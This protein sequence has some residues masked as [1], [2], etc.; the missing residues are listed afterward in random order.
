MKAAVIHEWNTFSLEEVDTPVIGKE[1]ALLKV[2]YCGICHS[3][4]RASQGLNP[5]AARPLIVGHEFSATVADIDS[6]ARP[7]IQVGD[8]VCAHIIQSCGLCDTCRKGHPNLCRSMKVLGT[9]LPGTMAEY[10]KVPVTKLYKLP[11]DADL[12]LYALAEPLTV[13]VY[14]VQE[15]G[16]KLGD[17]VFIIGGGPIGLC[18]A[19]AAKLSGASKI[20]VSELQEEKRSLIEGMGFIMVNPLDGDIVER[21]M[22]LTEGKGYDQVYETS[23]SAAGTSIVTALAAPRAVGMIVGQN[24]EKLPVSTWE[25]MNREMQL[26]SIRTHRQEAFEAAVE[27]IKSGAIT[28]ELYQLITMDYDFNQIQEAF[29]HCINYT[30]YCK[31]MIRIAGE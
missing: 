11:Q 9:Q 26:R 28:A 14:S 16:L 15:A 8:K 17:R 23:G 10:V 5:R 22:E 18:C 19:L 13:G 21:A 1:E 7:D 24:T 20:V 12:R 27:I 2:A 6:A 31:V 25:M 4:V 3:D 30:D 29:E